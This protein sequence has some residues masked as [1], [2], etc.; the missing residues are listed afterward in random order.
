MSQET[1]CQLLHLINGSPIAIY[2]DCALLPE[3]AGVEGSCSN[4]ECAKDGS[5]NSVESP[6]SLSSSSSDSESSS[7]S[8]SDSEMT[9]EQS[10][11]LVQGVLAILAIRMKSTSEMLIMTAVHNYFSNGKLT[12]ML[13]FSRVLQCHFEKKDSTLSDAFSQLTELLDPLV[14]DLD[15]KERSDYLVDSLRG[16]LIYF[17]LCFSDNKVTS[18]QE[19]NDA[20]YDSFMNALSQGKYYRLYGMLLTCQELF[21]QPDKNMVFDIIHEHIVSLCPNLDD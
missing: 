10:L 8:R 6:P 2:G 5:S 1:D 14:M 21:Q 19:V 15:L 13:A 20:L 12:E 18:S 11:E 3:N 9:I 17:K 4:G 16:V 7:E